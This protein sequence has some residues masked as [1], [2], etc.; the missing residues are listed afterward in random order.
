MRTN[1]MAI[2]YLRRAKSRLID[3]KSALKRG[4]YPETSRR[5]GH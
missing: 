3:A 1:I 2:D 4:D 5:R